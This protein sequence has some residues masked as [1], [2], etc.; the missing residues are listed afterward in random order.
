MANAQTQPQQTA[1]VIDQLA[2]G[3]SDLFTAAN[4]ANG[5]ATEVQPAI[6]INATGCGWGSVPARAVALI[7]KHPDLAKA[8]LR[9][10]VA[11]LADPAKVKAILGAKRAKLSGK[12]KAPAVAGADDLDAMLNQL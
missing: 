11:E 7:L 1:D 9:Q 4:F 3:T 8:A 6:R 2:G 5:K 12:G 10:S